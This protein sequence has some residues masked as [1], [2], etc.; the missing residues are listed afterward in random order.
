LV[1]QLTEE[2]RLLAVENGWRL[3]VLTPSP[4]CES[5]S[6][7]EPE[8]NGISLGLHAGAEDLMLFFDSDGTLRNPAL[9]VAGED[10]EVTQLCQIKTQ[11]APPDVHIAVVDLLRDLG[12]RFFEAL[13]VDDEGQYW[14][15][16]NRDLL[17]ANLESLNQRIDGAA[18]VLSALPG[19]PASGE[20]TAELADRIE[21]ALARYQSEGSPDVN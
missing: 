6:C 2:M 9:L 5:S 17:V 8:L 16:G 7:D 20:S 21:E 19:S 12:Q 13:H 11:F 4:D 18:R 1:D 10:P 3:A 14:E 15:T